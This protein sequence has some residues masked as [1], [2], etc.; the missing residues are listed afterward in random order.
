MSLLCS[1]LPSVKP[2][3]LTQLFVLFYHP[4]TLMLRTLL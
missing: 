1:A 2:I 3:R 4:H